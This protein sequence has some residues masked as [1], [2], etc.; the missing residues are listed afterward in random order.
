MLNVLKQARAAFS[1][2]NPQDIRESAERPIQIGIVAD[3]SSAYAEMEDFL[4][5]AGMPRREWTQR[6]NQVYRANC[7]TPPSRVD[8][9]LYEPGLACPQDAY[10]FHRDHPEI[11]VAE[12]LKDK[13]D[14]AIALARQFPAF[15]RPVVEQIIHSVARENAL[16]TIATALPNIVPNLIELPWAL[17][18][19]A[20]DTAFLTT[21]QVR[22]A[23]QIAAACGKEVGLAEQKGTVFGIVGSAFGWRALARELVSHIP[24]GGGLIPKGAIA[25]AG[26]FLVG[27]SLEFMLVQDRQHTNEERERLYQEGL[28]YGRSYAGAL[29]PHESKA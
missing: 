2:L 20:S 3:G 9:V 24:L 27:K 12:I 22:M 15:R 10:T 13:N 14:L 21:N 23:F 11:T 28:E 1:L 29:H 8:I 16:F 7:A 25:Y 6:M 26:T 5:P 17:G 19:F 4:V 18:E